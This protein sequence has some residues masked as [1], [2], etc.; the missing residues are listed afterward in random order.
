LAARNCEPN[1]RNVTKFNGRPKSS[2]FDI[3]HSAK[4]LSL[5]VNGFRRLEDPNLHEHDFAFMVGE[6]RYSCPSFVAEFLSPRVSSLRSQ[7]ITIDEFS[8]ETADPSNYFSS[9]LSI[10]FGHEVSFSLNELSFLRSVCGE[11]GNRELF[12]KTL[13]AHEG[14]VEESEFK[15]RL[16]FLS[17]LDGSFDMDV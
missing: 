15:A 12:E 10:G 8:I 1:D 16:V 5:S 17:H 3:S 9:L 7:D 4:R 2:Q 6:E 13:M 11:L 14:E